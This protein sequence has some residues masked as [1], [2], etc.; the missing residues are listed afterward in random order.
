M[1]LR[2]CVTPEGKFIFGIH[3]PNFKTANLREND[4]LQILGLDTADNPVDNTRNFPEG[5]VEETQGEWIY[6]IPN[7]F[8]FR[9]AS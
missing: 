3:K 8:P 6:E 9:G 4:F 5:D 2:T 7:P 1:K